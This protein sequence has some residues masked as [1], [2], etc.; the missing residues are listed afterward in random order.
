MFI[1]D[2]IRLPIMPY[3]V[4]FFWLSFV[5]DRAETSLKTK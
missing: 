3:L 2:A 4:S 5:F 1:G